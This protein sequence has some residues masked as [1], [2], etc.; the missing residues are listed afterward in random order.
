MNRRALPQAPPV[1]GALSFPRSCVAFQ[2]VLRYFSLMKMALYPSVLLFVAATAFGQ[3]TQRRTELNKLVPPATRLSG[4]Q[5]EKASEM[6]DLV[7]DD[8]GS[9]TPAMVSRHFNRSVHL[10]LPGIEQGQF[11]HDQAA[12]L[13]AAYLR[14]SRALSVEVKKREDSLAAPYFSA[15]FRLVK[16]DREQDLS[17]YVSLV[18]TGDAWTIGHFSIY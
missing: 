16:D 7:R 11:S 15:S 2:P 14:S 6:F 9:S 18:R 12:Q 1:P 13:L 5:Q 4:A 3:V 8:L 17:L 10:A